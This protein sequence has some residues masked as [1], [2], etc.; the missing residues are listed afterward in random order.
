MQTDV[1]ITLDISA[2]LVTE[3]DAKSDVQK[4]V[5]RQLKSMWQKIDVVPNDVQIASGC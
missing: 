5:L 3:C 2:F 4:P 1:I